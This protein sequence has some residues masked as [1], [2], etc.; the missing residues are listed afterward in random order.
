VTCTRPDVAA[1]GRQAAAVAITE[2][3]RD[4][5]DIPDDPEQCA[6][7]T[8]YLRAT[9][10]EAPYPARNAKRQPRQWC[11]DFWA[12]CWHGAGTGL[13]E[14]IRDVLLQSTYRL[15][16]FGGFAKDARL[17]PFKSVAYQGRTL[18]VGDWLAD[19]PRYA[20]RCGYHGSAL[21]DLEAILPGDLLTVPG[22]SGSRGRWGEGGHIALAAGVDRGFVLT[23]EGNS[24]GPGPHGDRREGVVW[25]LRTKEEVC[26]HLRPSPL[27]LLPG[28]EYL[29]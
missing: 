11:G 17:W 9:G 8:R 27:D 14:P 5:R 3:L 18:F 10:T 24:T 21:V 16:I 4:V 29:R 25:H 22:A 26:L 7:I 2:W 6:L 15:L 28:V 13:H 12:W 23:Y 19:E 1:A 20:R